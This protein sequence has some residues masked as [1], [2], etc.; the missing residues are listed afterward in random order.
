MRIERLTISNFRRFAQADVEFPD[1]VTALVG[2]NGAGKST[3]LEAMGWC[4]FGHDAARTGK[5]LI[6]RHGAAPGDDVRVALAFRFGGHTYEV[7]RELLGKSQSHVATVMVDD[8]VVVPGGA[9]SHREATQYLGRVFHMDRE[10]FFT[11]LVAR[12]RELSALT[13]ARASDRKR[14]LIGLLRLDAV[15][16]A[17]QEARARRRDARNTL[18]GLRQALKDPKPLE[19]ALATT[20]TLMARDRDAMTES[21]ARI[22]SLEEQVEDARAK[23]DASRKRAESWRQVE[24]QLRLAEQRIAHLSGERQRHDTDLARARAAA[25]EAAQLAP[26]LAELPSLAERLQTL[27]ALQARH[28]E[29]TRC[30]TELTR[31]LAEVAKARAEVEAIQ[32]A[33]AAAGTVRSLQDRVAKERA[34]LDTALADVQ[35]R[36]ATLAAGSQET[37]RRL[38][39]AEATAARVRSMGPDS[40]C[41][42]CTRPLR[43]HHDA[44][45][46]DFAK[47]VQAH[48][49]ALAEVAP[50]LEAARAAEQET[51]AQIVAL[52]GREQELRTKL[53]GIARDE[54]R[55]DGAKR[56]VM[57]TQERAQLLADREKALAAEPFD[58]QTF[59][60]VRE[61]VRTLEQVR[62]KHARLAGVAAR[63]TDIIGVL[64]E[65]A[66]STKA[67]QAEAA[68]LKAQRDALA[69]DA[70]AHEALEVAAAGAEA[71]LTEARLSRERLLGEQA[72]RVDEEKR[73]VADL[74]AQ[75]ALAAR[76]HT[77]EG[78]LRLLETLAGDREQGLL[79]EFKDHLIGRIRP[80][81]SVHAGRLFRELTDGRYA[82]LEVDEDYG[83]RVHEDG[84]TFELERY[85]GGEGDL[86]NLCL[87]LAV[88]QV[89]AERAGAEGFGF[90]ALDEVF[91]SQDEVRKAN[92]LR[93]L[94]GLSGRF[95]QILIITHIQ[96]VKDAAENVLRV[97]ALDDGTSRLTIEA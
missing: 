23:R 14:I 60:A 58:P 49:D 83:L 69:F 93:S 42:T 77:L 7:V 18:A 20:R 21:A 46:H 90:L 43:E 88:S 17:I 29:L 22:R 47:T 66:E 19:D 52:A 39:E 32:S 61:R 85:S 6:K 54:A 34:R 78:Q 30:R 79:P 96:D 67:A 81:L 35:A 51:R 80:V 72:R 3:V 82:D 31:T 26:Q 71:R 97:E 41:P 91:G 4:L 63:E 75:R 56:R 33:L 92:I 44:L 1:G 15:D 86:A 40:P 2:R 5:D 59:Q 50:Q 11:S 65:M 53:A 73:L 27:S 89:V 87:R 25:A 36:A 38:A 95:R 62:E 55:L 24:N 10:A 57:E 68:A 37:A 8:R 84:A 74:D 76:A 13:D 64:A 70:K 48:R 9:Q 94:K 28:E 45:L 12:Q 16:A